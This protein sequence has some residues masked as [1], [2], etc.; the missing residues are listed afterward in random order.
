MTGWRKRQVI[1]MAREAGMS[2]TELFGAQR[3]ID[4]W[5]ADLER[6][7]KLVREDERERIKEENQRC[8]V[9]RGQ[10]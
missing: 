6:F 2:F 9:T 8:Y 1:E 5:L 3:I 7:A 4:G 10:A